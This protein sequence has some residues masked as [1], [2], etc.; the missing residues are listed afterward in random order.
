MKF[1]KT[2]GLGKHPIYKVWK[3]MKSRCY[4]VTAT[5]YKNY[6]GRGIKVCERWH[7]FQKFYGDMGE[8]YKKGLQLDRADNSGDY[9]LLNCQW[10]TRSQNCRNTRENIIVTFRGS[11]RCLTECAEI[12]N[13]P[14]GTLL[15]RYYHNIPLD[16]PLYKRAIK[17]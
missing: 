12:L 6:G 8:A 13:R 9:S 4:I 10:V 17:G 11:K 2:H 16:N 3:G 7:D 5:G 14:F 15:Y 1:S